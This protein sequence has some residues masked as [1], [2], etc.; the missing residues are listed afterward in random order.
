MVMGF[1][2]VM[3]TMVIEFRDVQIWGLFTLLWL[4]LYY[5]LYVQVWLLYVVVF[6]D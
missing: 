3:L 5:G 4:V 2:S 6:A 1:D